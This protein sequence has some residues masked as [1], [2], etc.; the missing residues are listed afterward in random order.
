MG[1]VDLSLT[2]QPASV[3]AARQLVRRRCEEWGADAAASDA[4]VL[5]AS[6]LV[7]NAVLHARTPLTLTVAEGDGTI[8]VEVRD[9][10]P[11]LPQARRYNVDTA[12]GRG[13]RLLET[14]ASAWGVLKVPSAEQPG[15][16]VW[17]EVPLVTDATVD[18]ALLAAAFKDVLLV[19]WLE[20]PEPAGPGQT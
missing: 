19:E 17:F 14:I 5:L 18:E 13:L 2:A 15:K 9:W 10:H 11:A 6:E 12:T 3:P 8:R 20:E 16:I 7:T 1:P 4:A